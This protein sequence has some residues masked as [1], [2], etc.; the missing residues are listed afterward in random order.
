MIY[1]HEKREKK[2]RYTGPRPGFPEHDESLDRAMQKYLH[3]RGL[4]YPLAVSN[5][6]YPAVYKGCD[7]MIIPCSNTLRV[8]YFQGRDITGTHKLRYDSPASPR[9]DSIVLMWPDGRVR[10][11]VVV[12]GPTD[13]LAAAQHGFLGVGLMGNSPTAEVKTAVASHARTFSPV[14][15]VPDRDRLEM[16]SEMVCFLRQCGIRVSMRI[17]VDKDLAAMSAAR[18]DMFLWL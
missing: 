7:R 12:E 4:S 8:P 3:G 10:G 13:A 9:D 14:L 6:W 1:E 2:T 16:G 17:L 15:V 18:R 11:M 5:G